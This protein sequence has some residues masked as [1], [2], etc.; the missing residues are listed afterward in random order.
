M[1]RKMASLP[2]EPVYSALLL[3]SADAKYSCVKE[4]LTVVSML[5]SDSIF[6][7]PHKENDKMAAS[8]A[9]KV[10]A[11]SDGDIPTLLNI[12]TA[13]S[14][15]R[16]SFEWASQ[17]YLSQRALLTEEQHRKGLWGSLGRG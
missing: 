11:N 7:Q 4:M 10:L 17:H 1:G 2:L 13:W 16:R 14:Y 6:L 8:R 15:S 5:S 3:L 9:H 12:F